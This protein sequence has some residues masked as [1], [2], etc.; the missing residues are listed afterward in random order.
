MRPICT[1]LCESFLILAGL[2]LRRLMLDG[3]ICYITRP[4][5]IYEMMRENCVSHDMALLNNSR[6]IDF[7]PACRVAIQGSSD[8]YMFEKF[9]VGCRGLRV[10]VVDLYSIEMTPFSIA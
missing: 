1:T 9:L 8:E 6:V 10:Q 4:R 5:W 3:F 7:G 2:C